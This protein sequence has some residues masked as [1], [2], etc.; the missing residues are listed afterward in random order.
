MILSRIIPTLLLSERGLYKTRRFGDPVYLGDPVNVINIY[1]E[2]QVDEIVVFDIDAHRTGQI[3]WVM[4]KQ[5]AGEC[6]M[7][8]CYGGGITTVDEIQTILGLGI[9]KVS[10]NS[11]AYGDID[12]IRKAVAEA[13]SQSIAATIDYRRDATGTAMCYS[14]GGTRGQGISVTD[15][16]RRLVDAGVGEIVIYDIDR[17]GMK[18]GYDLET[19]RKVT[20]AVDIPVVCC[21]GVRDVPDLRE[22]LLAG[23]SACA[24]GSLF[25]FIGRLD[26]VLITYPNPEKLETELRDAAVIVT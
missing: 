19:I 14:H 2:K 22:G 24:A 3:D 21:G 6:F 12:F 15:H 11:A 10:V 16:A 25:C 13:G 1:N 7:P 9:E 4:L 18:T 8:L 20:D 26:A 23:A 17:D 5:M